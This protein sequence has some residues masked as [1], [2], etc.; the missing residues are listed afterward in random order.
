MALTWFK[1]GNEYR[2]LDGR[3]TIWGDDR[4]GFTLD[5]TLDDGE[6]ISW[7][8]PG[9]F[10][11]V[12]EAKK[13]AERAS[14]KSLP[15]TET[16]AKTAR[17]RAR[18]RLAWIG[19]PRN[20]RPIEE[21]TYGVE[22]LLS[23]SPN[24]A[25]LR[26]FDFAM[27]VAKDDVPDEMLRKKGKRHHPSHVAS[28]AKAVSDRQRQW[29]LEYWLCPNDYITALSICVPRASYSLRGGN[30]HPLVAVPTSV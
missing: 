23:F 17:A 21:Y 16:K 4:R 1:N 2:S 22:A 6:R 20:G 9:A 18:T 13:Q 3:W 26:R 12:E 15:A 10:D 7:S 8:V 25:D 30:D 24:E 27:A 29:G 5:H 11:S 14:R 28:S 19:N